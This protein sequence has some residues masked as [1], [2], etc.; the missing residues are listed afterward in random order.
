MPTEAGVIIIADEVGGVQ[1]HATAQCCHCG[2][3]FVMRNG[4]G[5]RRGWCFKCP[6]VVCGPGCAECVPIEKRLDLAE[7]G[8]Q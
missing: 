6:G 5:V 2:T 8:L 1:E 4:S 7:R 3:H